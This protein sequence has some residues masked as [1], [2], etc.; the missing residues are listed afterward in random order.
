M[1]LRKKN[2][3]CLAGIVL[4]CVIAFCAIFTAVGAQS[5]SAEGIEAKTQGAETFAAGERNIEV[6]GTVCTVEGKALSG[7]TVT[8]GSVTAHS[9]QDGTFCIQSADGYVTFEKEG[10]YKTVSFCGKRADSYALRVEM[11]PLSAY[12]PI[13]GRADPSDE[14]VWLEKQ[15]YLS[16]ARKEEGLALSYQI[17]DD[18]ICFG[19]ENNTDTD[20]GAYA[21]T[22]SVEIFIDTAASF[23]AISTEQIYGIG[24]YPNGMFHVLQGR[25]GQWA[26]CES[27]MCFTV[28]MMGTADDDIADKGYRVEIFIPYEAIGLDSTQEFSFAACTRGVGTYAQN[29]WNGMSTAN[30]KYA[31]DPNL[32]V[33]YQLFTT[34]GEIM[35]VEEKNS[36]EIDAAYLDGLAIIDAEKVLPFEAGNFLYEDWW[37]KISRYAPEQLEGLNYIFGSVEQ[38]SRGTVTKSGW[39]IAFVPTIS[40]VKQKASLTEAGWQLIATSVW[41]IANGQLENEMGPSDFYAAYFEEGEEVGIDFRSVILFGQSEDVVYYE[42]EW[43]KVPARIFFPEEYTTPEVLWYGVGSSQ[44]LSNGTMLAI[45]MSGGAHEPDPL[46]YIIVDISKDE[47]KTWQRAFY[48]DYPTE[49]YRAWSPRVWQDPE[50]NLWLSWSQSNE[51]FDRGGVWMCKVTNLDADVRDW[52]FS[53][54]KRVYD[55][56]NMTK[57]IVIEDENGDELYLDAVYS[58]KDLGTTYIYASSDQGETWQLRGTVDVGNDAQMCHEGTLVEVAPGVIWLEYR[59][60]AYPAGESYSYDYGKTWT[61]GKRSY[62]KAGYS[63]STFHKTESGK[64]LFVSNDEAKRD[65][66]CVYIL[67]NNGKTF[68]VRAKLCLDPRPAGPINNVGAAYPSV[69]ERDGKIYIV[70]DYDRNVVGCVT[71]AIITEQRIYEG[72]C[73]REDELIFIN[74]IPQ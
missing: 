67:D 37:P 61:K 19:M 17:V 32:P 74:Q 64:I 8:S 55:G 54:P 3:L 14:A 70:W 58:F 60:T 1:E 69:S 16:M 65:K 35:L 62:L 30:G 2:L 38:G 23:S 53:E 11:M 49:K 43:N 27:I 68:A 9:G 29:R 48:I 56:E 41:Q 13:T 22:D 71:M 15:A 73:L 31:T 72:G 33:T 7:V 4:L 21:E 51:Y 47:G 52:N 5:L 6:V 24:I 40:S 66:L 28:T 57:P 20:A 50:G 39:V 45:Y 42:H 46:N 44:M 36:L 26:A 18:N 25:A 10:F 59:G 63:L 34:D 12:S